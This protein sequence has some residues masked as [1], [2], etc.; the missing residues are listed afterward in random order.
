MLLPLAWAD[1]LAAVDLL[2]VALATIAFMKMC[3][4]GFELRDRA[5]ATTTTSSV[6]ANAAGDAGDD[7]EMSETS[8][9]MDDDDDDDDDEASGAVLCSR[10]TSGNKLRSNFITSS[11][12]ST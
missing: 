7:D 1:L 11:G 4:E 12:E 9:A 6:A 3:S 5:E 2:T 8:V 10:L